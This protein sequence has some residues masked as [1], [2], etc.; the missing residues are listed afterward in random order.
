MTKSA[1]GAWVP[2]EE[3][4]DMG[5]PP[6]S[7]MKLLEEDGKKGIIVNGVLAWAV[8]NKE[9][10]AVG[11]WL[12]VLEQHYDK[13]ELHEARNLLL[14]TVP[15]LKEEMP[16]LKRARQKLSLV[17]SDIRMCLE[18]LSTNENLMPLVMATSEQWRQSP[19][20]LGSSEPNA[21][22]G[23]MASKV[24]ML[25]ET[26]GKLM[27]TSSKQMEDLTEVLKVKKVQNQTK[28]ASDKE[29][30][31]EVQQVEEIH[32]GKENTYA[33]ATTNHLNQPKHQIIK[34]VLQK[35]TQQKSERP[36]QKMKN[37]FHGNNQTKHEENSI[38]ADV[39]LVAF[40]VSLDVETNHLEDFL[41]AR[42]LKVKKVELM[43]R[44]ELL[45]EN[46]VRSKSMKVTVTSSEYEKAMN[47]EMWPFRVGVRHFKAASRRPEQD[48]AGQ[49]QEEVQGGGDRSQGARL[50]RQQQQQ[51]QGPPGSREY[52]QR[53]RRNQYMEVGGWQT[54]RTALTVEDLLELL[55]RP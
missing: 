26:M 16:D 51:P 49:V 43:T 39:D 25:E 54:P 35:I 8:A 6:D 23:Q 29:H 32:A 52:G 38:A 28:D 11:I 47:P 36:K 19:K 53:K 48:A 41:I 12:Q 50:G 55:G 45:K 27:N 34:Q 1:A 3:E 40:G 10:G 17:M 15:A 42:G 37:V 46:K 20:S 4:E 33:N 24:K 13:D 21:T 2:G 7:V 30:V 18:Y 5:K 22:L 9:S 31:V 44:P 14:L